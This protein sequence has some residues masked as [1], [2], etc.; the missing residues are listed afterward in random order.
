M[1]D[2]LRGSRTS[3]SASYSVLLFLLVLYFATVGI[4]DITG[5]VAYTRLSQGLGVIIAIVVLDRIK[6]SEAIIW[7]TVAVLS[8]LFLTKLLVVEH[9]VYF[10]GLYII[11]IAGVG[12]ALHRWTA[13]TPS[14]VSRLFSLAAIAFSL[15]IVLYH[16][17]FHGDP[18]EIFPR[19]SR[20]HIATIGFSLFA[21]AAL[22]AYSVK[23]CNSSHVSWAVVASG[24]LT[25]LVL[26][27]CTGRTGIVL[28]AVILGAVILLAPKKTVVVLLIFGVVV[29]GGLLAMGPSQGFDGTLLMSSWSRFSIEG[30]DSPRWGIWQSAFQAAEHTWTSPFG[31][32]VGQSVEL[33]GLTWHNDILQA[34]VHYGALG[35]AL[36]LIL[37]VT[38]FVRTLRQSAFLVV[39]LMGITIRA[40]FDTTIFGSILGI[41]LVLLALV[42]LNKR[43]PNGTA[44]SRQS[45][46]PGRPTGLNASGSPDCD[47]VRPT[48]Y[49]TVPRV[50]P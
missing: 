44:N 20:N 3:L 8:V 9:D 12:I 7:A 25:S 36:L 11:V 18:N 41:P 15:F 13:R 2:P 14:T 17:A 22:S 37:Y 42:A 43:E 49:G 19:A 5:E 26:F 29:G 46:P 30:L 38:L 6:S 45:G 23:R 10:T 50:I 39:I 34:Y 48:P 47:N 33:T 1:H 21:I 31:L 4:S 28:S 32:P 35:F 24:V 16:F 27:A 40:F